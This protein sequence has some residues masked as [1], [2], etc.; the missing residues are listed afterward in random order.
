MPL[1]LAIE[2]IQ[3]STNNKA[4]SKALLAVRATWI[5]APT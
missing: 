1:L 3:R 5:A 4:L 2:G